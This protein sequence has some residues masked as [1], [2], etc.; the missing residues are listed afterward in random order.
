MKVFISWS[1]TRSRH[2]ADALR[3]WL[4]NVLQAVVPFIST[5]DIQK[6]SRGN[7]RISSELELANVGIICLTP[8]NLQ[9]AWILFEAGALSKLSSAYV[10][11]YLFD[12]RWSDVPPPLSQFQ[13]TTAEKEDNRQ[14]VATIN[15]ELPEDRRLDAARL[16]KTFETWW[17]TLQKQLDTVPEKPQA[18]AAPPH[19]TQEDKLDEVLAAVRSL[20][21]FERPRRRITLRVE[22][23]PNEPAMLDSISTLTAIYDPP[24]EIIGDDVGHGFTY[25][26]DAVRVPR[27]VFEAARTQIEKLGGVLKEL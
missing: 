16:E 25:S 1:G 8:E 18:E 26:A 9:S 22:G 10:C 20:A 27:Y 4:P 7:V 6:G 24:I 19:R 12:V 23:L 17:P 11:T 2:V 5:Q 14:L 13:H 3:D 15:A 21:P